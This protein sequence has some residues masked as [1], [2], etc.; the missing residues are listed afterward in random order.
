MKEPEVNIVDEVVGGET[1]K[2]MMFELKDYKVNG[3]T[4][5]GE[6]WNGNGGHQ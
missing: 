3:K 5:L 4:Q 1:L 2:E 6:E